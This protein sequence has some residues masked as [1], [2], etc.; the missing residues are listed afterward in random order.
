MKVLKV[1]DLA[2]LSRGE[3]VGDDSKEMTAVATLSQAGSSDISFYANKKYAKSLLTSK[4]GVVIVSEESKG[5]RPPDGQT[6]I[7][8]KNPNSAFQKAVEYFAPPPVSFP[9][10]THPSA[11]VAETAKVDTSCHVGPCA[12]I[13]P[14]AVI[15]KNTVICGGVYVGH[16]VRIGEKCLLRPNVVVRERCEIG[17]R[18]NIH[19]NVSIGDDGFGFDPTPMG[20]QKIPQLGIVKIDDDVEIGA[21]S[22]IARARFGKTWIKRGVKMDSMVMLAHNV[23]V[24]ECSIIVGQAGAAGSAE[25]GRGVIIAA[26]AGINGHTT[27]GDGAIIG[28]CSGVT[29]DVP[30]GE[31]FI[32]TPAESKRDFGAR[33]IL[34]NSVKRLF[35]KIKELTTE[36]ESLKSEMAVLKKG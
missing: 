14:G 20:P 7:I 3:V 11:V 33:L 10:G 28:G 34:P 5:Q 4:A 24:G 29:K 31:L 35:G 26:Q 2:R 23:T 17:N 32:G 25:I 13:E 30:P 1:K 9:P 6:W 15:G 18:V 21:N 22:T 19:A 27:V 36:I 8:C 16:D 12:I